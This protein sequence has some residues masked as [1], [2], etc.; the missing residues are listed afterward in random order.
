MHNSKSTKAGSNPF[1]PSLKKA[2]PNTFEIFSVVG[3]PFSLLWCILYVYYLKNKALINFRILSA[4][5][6]EL[7]Q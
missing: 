4:I 7:S 2:L 3:Q 6:L 1:P 5:N